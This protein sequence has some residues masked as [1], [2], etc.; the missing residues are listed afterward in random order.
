MPAGIKILQQ[1]KVSGKL[2][3]LLFSQNSSGNLI[4]INRKLLCPD[5]NI[6]ISLCAS[7]GN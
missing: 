1:A 3:Q 7:T 4:N 6:F 5:R 2:R